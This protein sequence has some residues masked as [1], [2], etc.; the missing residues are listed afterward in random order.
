MRRWKFGI[1]LLSIAVLL[2]VTAWRARQ[3][4][5]PESP[6]GAQVGFN[7]GGQEFSVVGT[8]VFVELARTP[9]EWARGLGFRTSLPENAGMLFVFPTPLQQTFWMK[10]T[11]IPLDLLWIRDRR[12]IGVAEHIQPE[13]GV[14]DIGL[15]RYSSPGPV[16][17]VLE[18]NAGWVLRHGIRVGDTADFATSDACAEG[19]AQCVRGTKGLL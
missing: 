9:A 3:T 16:D 12:V 18:V 6:N 10:D 14:P 19:D 8:R 17:R 4:Y 7:A 13:P 2:G 1:L 11:Y 15:R 5:F